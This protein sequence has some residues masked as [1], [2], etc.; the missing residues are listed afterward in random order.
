[1]SEKTRTLPD[2]PNTGKISYATK[3]VPFDQRYYT[4]GYSKRKKE[5]VL[6]VYKCR[7]CPYFHVS[8]ES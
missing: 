3:H 1:M 7:H 8:H 6:R 5:V 4:R 2:C